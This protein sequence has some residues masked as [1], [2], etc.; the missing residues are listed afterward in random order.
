MTELCNTCLGCT[1]LED[2]N[3]HGVYRCPNWVNGQK[4]ENEQMK[5]EGSEHER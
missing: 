4:P 1:R 2:S 5:M 3:F